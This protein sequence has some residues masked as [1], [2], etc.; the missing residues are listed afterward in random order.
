MAAGSPMRERGWGLP[1][2]ECSARRTHST[3][4]CPRSCNVAGGICCWCCHCVGL[5]APAAAACSV[6]GPQDGTAQQRAHH[7]ADEVKQR[8]AQRGA[9]VVFQEQLQCRWA[10]RQMPGGRLGKWES[11]PHRTDQL[12]R[13]S[14][15]KKCAA[16]WPR[17]AA[18]G[19]AHGGSVGLA[20]PGHRRA[21]LGASGVGGAAALPT[22]GWPPTQGCL[23]QPRIVRCSAAPHAARPGAAL[24]SPG[25]RQTARCRSPAPPA[26]PR[27]R[28]GRQTG[29][30][31]CWPPHTAGGVRVGTPD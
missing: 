13:E 7:I 2:L 10:G 29:R 16:D 24:A 15:L 23:L 26:G 3:A 21:S 18:Q 12:Q 22:A 27:W 25:R 11:L 20:S 6:S 30:R 28:S 17:H 14:Q 9:E 5:T 1:P 4:V 31:W 8:L 19:D